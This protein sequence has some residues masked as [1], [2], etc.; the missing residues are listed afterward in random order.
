M[1]IRKKKIRGIF[2][3]SVLIILC[4]GMASVLSFFT[5]NKSADAIIDISLQNNI[6]ELLISG[7]E[8]ESNTS[9]RIF[10]SERLTELFSSITNIGNATITQVENAGVKNSDDF[11]SFNGNTDDSNIVVT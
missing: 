6:D 7:Y 1:D 10:D 5:P 4:L 2:V 3:L 9:K 11:R 8:N